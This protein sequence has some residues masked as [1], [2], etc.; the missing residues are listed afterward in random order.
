MAPVDGIPQRIF[1]HKDLAVVPIVVERTAD[2]DAPAEIDIGQTVGHD[3]A[4]DNHAGRDAHRAQANSSGDHHGG[5]VWGDATDWTATDWRA[6]VPVAPFF[7][8]RCALIASEDACAPVGC[9]PVAIV[10][11]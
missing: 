10:R 3:L 2:Q 7:S 9:A 4:I 1:F 5:G 6:T 11:A 8:S